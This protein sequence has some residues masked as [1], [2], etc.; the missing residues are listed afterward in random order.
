MKDSLS[1]AI[2]RTIHTVI[3][4]VMACSTFILLYAGITASYGPWLYVALV[5]LVLESIVFAGNGMRCPLTKVAVKYG[6]KKG[7]AFDTFLP[8]RFTRYTFRF[9]GTVMFAGLILLA[10]RWIGLIR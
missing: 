9:F 10:A 8:E 3:Y 2:V 1:L 4:V 7:Y 6:A 5:L